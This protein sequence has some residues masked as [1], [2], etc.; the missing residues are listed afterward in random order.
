MADTEKKPSESVAK[1]DWQAP[2]I[3]SLD[4]PS[5]TKTGSNRLDPLEGFFAYRPS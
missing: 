5:T 1:K 4:I 2:E 3:K